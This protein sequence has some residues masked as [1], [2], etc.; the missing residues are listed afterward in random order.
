MRATEGST[1][2]SAARIPAVAVGAALLVAGA[3]DARA[4]RA[5]DVPVIVGFHRDVDPGIFARHGGRARNDLGPVLRA[6][7]GTVPAARVGALLAEP[8]VAYIEEDAVRTKRATPNDTYYARYQA[9]SY[10]LIRLPAAWDVS[11]GAGVRVAVLDTGCEVAHPDIGSGATGKVKAVRNF[12]TRDTADVRDPDGH[13]THTAG[14]VGAL[15]GNGR[16]VAGA[17]YLCEL[18]IAKVL[19]PS[20]AYDSWTAGAITWSWQTA[21]ARVVSMSLG[22]PGYTYTLEAA[23][24]RATRAGVVLVAA[25]G[26]AASSRGEYPAA[27]PTCISVAAT[28]S[29]GRRA[30][31]SNYGRTVDIAAP[32]VSILATWPGGQYVYSSGTSMA[33]PIVSGVAALVLAATPGA[34]G[35]AVRER[36]LATRVDTG[37]DYPDGTPILRVDA[38]SAVRPPQ[39]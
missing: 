12:T 24:S 32:G 29:T 9:A 11:R 14:T 21:G 34:T 37:F 4:A 31:F 22:G 38:L 30:S 39:P 35:A 3:L 19:S 15:T 17:G 13:G 25:A 8:G 26:N 27:F 20:G 28:T 23:V 5:Q 1:H 6:C 10:G 7:A 33:T 18:A 36:L 16:G 2:R